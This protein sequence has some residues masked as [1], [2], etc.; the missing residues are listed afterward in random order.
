MTKDAF[1]SSI[2]EMVVKN[3]VPLKFFILPTFKKLIGELAKM[4]NIFLDKSNIRSLIIQ[5][6]NNQKN[7]L[8]NLMKN[9]FVFLK[10]DNCTRMQTIYIAINVHFMNNNMEVIIYSLAVKDTDT[11]HSSKSIEKIVSN[12]LDGYG[13]K[14]E[15]ILAIVTENA[16]NMIR[17]IKKNK[18]KCY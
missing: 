8:K 13:L 4:L 16:S 11:D 14:K 12:V 7:L 6:A 10:I 1:I 18:S 17:T 3:S 15:H 2:I 9:K 5:E